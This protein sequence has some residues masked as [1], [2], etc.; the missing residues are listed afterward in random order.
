MK[1]F[2][3]LLFSK[4][5]ILF[6]LFSFEM[7]ILFIVHTLNVLKPVHFTF[8]CLLSL[9]LCI[10]I[11]FIQCLIVYWLEKKKG[12]KRG[13]KWNER[14]KKRTQVKQKQTTSEKHHSI[15]C[16]K[17]PSVLM[18]KRFSIS[19]KLPVNF[20]ICT[21]EASTEVPE[22]EP[23]HNSDNINTRKVKSEKKLNELKYHLRK[24]YN[25]KINN[26]ILGYWRALFTKL[27]GS[28]ILQTSSDCKKYILHCDLVHTGTRSFPKT[29]AYQMQCYSILFCL[30]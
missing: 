15:L 7:F 18:P 5:K 22:S 24:K 6:L 25:R 17:F 30:W 2:K 12:C 11:F 19:K 21:A 10:L 27:H 3:I 20:S 9:C 29:S 13:H 1:N 8:R 28:N 26:P 23:Q 16:L 4:N 14:V